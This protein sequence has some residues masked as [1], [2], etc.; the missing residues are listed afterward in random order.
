M[1][2][3]TGGKTITRE[4]DVYERTRPL[5]VELHPK[6]LTIRLKGEGEPLMV[7]YGELLKMARRKR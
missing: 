4:T 3:L 1:T 5:V 6:Y 7:S 2:K